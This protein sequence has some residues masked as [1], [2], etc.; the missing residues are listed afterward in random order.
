MKL[1]QDIE[2]IFSSDTE[3]KISLE[4]FFQKINHKSFGVLL[5]ILSL[6]S[7]LPLSVP[8]LSTPFGIMLCF[9]GLQIIINR[10]F[11]WFPD[12][13]K[14]KQISTN[15][16]KKMTNLMVKFLKFFE[17][18]TGPRLKFLTKGIFY[19]ILGFIVVLCAISMMVPFPVTNS[20]SALGIFFIG[21]SFLEEDGVLTLIGSFVGCLGVALTAIFTWLIITVGWSGVELIINQIRNLF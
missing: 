20:L 17:R 18:F 4:S 8:G 1:S 6:P 11:V 16:N 9:L 15:Q 19:Q 7:S 14:K 10:Q 2:Q 13:I 3:Q 12:F 21:L 5:V